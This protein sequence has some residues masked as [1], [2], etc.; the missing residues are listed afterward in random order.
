V[1]PPSHHV[2]R[3]RN[4]DRDRIANPLGIPNRIDQEVVNDADYGDRV[5]ADDGGIGRYLNGDR[6]SRMLIDR[7]PL[8][9]HAREIQRLSLRK[10]RCGRL[11][12]R[13]QLQI[14]KQPTEL[15]DLL[16]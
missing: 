7:H 2:P 6:I 10:R 5:L 15:D 8:T 3:I 12:L 11:C 1:A 9:R 16:I 14:L 13:D 4:R